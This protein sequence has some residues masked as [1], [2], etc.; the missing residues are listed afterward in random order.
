MGDRVNEGH[1]QMT[2]YNDFLWHSVANDSQNT[3]DTMNVPWARIL[4]QHYHIIRDEW[5]AFEAAHP[6]ITR[7]NRVVCFWQAKSV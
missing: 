4:R 1:P 2:G 7:C 3:F 5:R 6:G